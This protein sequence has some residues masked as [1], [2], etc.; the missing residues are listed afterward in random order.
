MSNHEENTTIVESTP[1]DDVNLDNY[2]AEADLPE[3]AAPVTP[4]YTYPLIQYGKKVTVVSTRK[5][6]VSTSFLIATE[7]DATLDGILEQQL[8]A[9]E[10]RIRHRNG[11][12]D[13]YWQFDTI[14]CYMLCKAVPV[15]Y[16]PDVWQKTGVA[17]VWNEH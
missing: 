4:T 7:Q 13:T 17:Y 11:S 9:S 3:Y 5:P 14:K 10:V 6:T 1:T 2:A 15:F 16:G 8:G 12:E